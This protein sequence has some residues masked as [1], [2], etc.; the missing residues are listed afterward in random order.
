MKEEQFRQIPITA[1]TADVSEKTKI[2]IVQSGMND[3]LTKPI[4]TDHLYNSLKKYAR[5]S[6]QVTSFTDPAKTLFT[7]GSAK[8][9]KVVD[10]TLFDQ[11]FTKSPDEYVKFLKTYLEEF[12]NYYYNFLKSLSD[13]DIENFKRTHHKI[14]SA[15]HHL[16]IHELEHLLKKANAYLTNQEEYIEISYFEKEL[17]DQFDKVGKALVE[18]INQLTA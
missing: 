5:P 1:L 3:Y 2:S 4:N 16:K 18:K 9:A 6:S 13:K 10:F 8:T 12:D 11:L 14:N 17:H 15:I 7:S